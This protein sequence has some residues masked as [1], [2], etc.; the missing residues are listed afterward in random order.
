MEP[1]TLTPL[2]IS[3]FVVIGI[4][5]TVFLFFWWRFWCRFLAPP[6]RQ[7]DRDHIKRVNYFWIGHA[8]G[9]YILLWYVAKMLWSSEWEQLLEDLHIKGWL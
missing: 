4:I 6:S 5:I 9:N 8:I 7:C 1:I 3:F 2:V